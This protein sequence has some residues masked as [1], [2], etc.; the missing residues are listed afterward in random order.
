MSEKVA[1][2]PWHSRG[3]RKKNRAVL[4]QRLG[5]GKGVAEK[6]IVTKWL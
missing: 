2:G 3:G 6:K 4:K 5:K 1:K